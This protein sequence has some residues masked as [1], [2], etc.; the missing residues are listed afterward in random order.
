VALGTAIPLAINSVAFL[1]IHVCR[2]VG[3]RLSDYLREA[4]LTP[5]LIAVAIA[6]CLWITGRIVHTAT[7]A[8]VTL[9]LASGAAL[10]ALGILGARH[11]ATR[12][13]R[14]RTADETE[15]IQPS[16]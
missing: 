1:P 10:C 11:A 5:A 9:Q 12:L 6:A 2:I 4:H 7:Y 14:L 8:G 13:T 3:F 15:V 16:T